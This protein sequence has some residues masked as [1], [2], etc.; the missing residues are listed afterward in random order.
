MSAKF[1]LR[2]QVTNDLHH[3]APTFKRTKILNKFCTECLHRIS[4][5]AEKRFDPSY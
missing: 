3:I 5:K 1:N 4:W 2:H